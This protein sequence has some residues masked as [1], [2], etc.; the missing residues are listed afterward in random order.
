MTDAK[1]RS[2]SR[3]AAGIVR[4]CVAV[5]ELCAERETAAE[6]LERELGVTE[7]TQLVALLTRSGRRLHWRE[8]YLA[9]AR[10]EALAA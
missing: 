6:R 4:A 7:A 8:Q 10:Q 5:G 2:S 9:D 1:L 3:G